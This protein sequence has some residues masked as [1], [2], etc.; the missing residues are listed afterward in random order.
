MESINKEPTWL[1]VELNE[2]VKH[3]LLIPIETIVIMWLDKDLARIYLCYMFLGKIET[4]FMLS[5]K[6][7]AELMG[8]NFATYLKRRRELVDKGL[9]E[10]TNENSSFVKIRLDIEKLWEVLK[11]NT[12]GIKNYTPLFHFKTFEELLNYTKNTG[13]SIT[14]ELKKQKINVGQTALLDNIYIYNTPNKNDKNNYRIP[15]NNNI[16]NNNINTKVTYPKEDYEMVI[17]AFKK[18]KGVGLMGPE[19]SYHMRAIKMMFQAERT[20]KQIIDFMKWMHDNERNEETP[21]VKTWTIWTVQK[22]I[23]EFVG[24]KLKVADEKDEMERI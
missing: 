12:T 11:I 8:L 1:K 20:P 4:E 10:V 17:N 24:G 7:T 18:Y 14:E 5:Q 13:K 15:I 16:T 3:T 9:I 22:K 19:V 6:K 21:W 2:A 23:A